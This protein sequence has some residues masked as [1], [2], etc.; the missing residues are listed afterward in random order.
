M[1]AGIARPVLVLTA[2]DLEYAAVR[3]QL[4]GLR[5]HR[6]PAGTLFEAGRLAGCAGEV[7]IG[8]TGP[9]ITAA[10]LLAERATATFGPQAV[11]FAGVA[12]ALKDDIRLG[13]IVVA[14]KVYAYHGAKEEDDA[15]SA[16]PRSWDAP[17]ELEQTAH[18]IA[19]DRSWARYLPAS[20]LDH[21][22]DVHFKPIA[23]GEVLLAARAA[24]TAERL[25]RVY[26]DA[27]AIE[28]EG[29]GVSQASHVNRSLP[30]LIIRGISDRADGDKRALDQE[31]WQPRAAA[32][33]AAFAVALAA[34]LLSPGTGEPAAGDGGPGRPEDGEPARPGGPL[35]EVLDAQWPLDCW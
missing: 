2:L 24:P 32:H 26:N 31:G 35:G 9:G 7:I 29:A 18:A 23:T 30:A 27:A 34:E 20:P 22:P 12:G 3:A 8:L 28:M 14:T 4:R 19:Q 10:A 21:L 16:R 1:S 17:H 25:R 6:H 11:L 13:D 33:A 15:V 5:R